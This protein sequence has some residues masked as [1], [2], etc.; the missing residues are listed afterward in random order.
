MAKPKTVSWS[1][2]WIGSEITRTQMSVAKSSWQGSWGTVVECPPEQFTQTVRKPALLRIRPAS[3]SASPSISCDTD[4]KLTTPTLIV[5]LGSGT[6]L[7]LSTGTRNSTGS[8]TSARFATWAHS[9]PPMGK[10]K[11]PSIK[12]T[13]DNDRLMAATHSPRGA[14]PTVN[15]SQR[16]LHS[17]TVSGGRHLDDLALTA[18]STA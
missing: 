15:R 9:L 1:S 18:L 6:P 12:T 17:A 16:N 8:L 14:E 3:C 4:V 11:T 7:F 2:F 10:A 13:R 5:G